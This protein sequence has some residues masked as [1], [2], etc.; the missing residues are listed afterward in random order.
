[1]VFGKVLRSI[2]DAIDVVMD[3]ALMNGVM[4]LNWFKAQAC[5]RS[6]FWRG[7]ENSNK[8][9]FFR[10]CLGCCSKTPHIHLHWEIRLAGLALLSSRVR[11]SKRRCPKKD[12]NPN[13]TTAAKKNML[14]AHAR[15]K[16]KPSDS[17]LQVA[18][19]SHSAVGQLSARTWFSCFCGIRGQAW[20]G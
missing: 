12:E 18:R 17:T 14:C 1:M 19:G 10:S 3:Y 20:G 4:V 16:R 15:R 9:S 2:V 6:H 8:D 11:P 5:G 7:N 13:I